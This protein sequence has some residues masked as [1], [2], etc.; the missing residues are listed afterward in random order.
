MYRDA[1]G[2]RDANQIREE[3]LRPAVQGRSVRRSPL[4]GPGV[5]NLLD[6]SRD[7][8][9][10][11]AR[12]RP[13]FGNPPPVS[14]SLCPIAGGATCSDASTLSSRATPC[15]E[16]SPRILICRA[17]TITVASAAVSRAIGCVT[18]ARLTSH[19]PRKK[20]PNHL[21]VLSLG[22]LTREVS[23]RFYHLIIITRCASGGPERQRTALAGRAQSKACPTACGVYSSTSPG[24]SAGA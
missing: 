18:G 16:A 14:I 11:P 24:R 12:V 10:L 7:V 17:L 21:L 20:S 13:R 22:S 9:R 1:M 19:A 2:I 4:I 3:G 23:R 8:T 6:M 15:S 5:Q